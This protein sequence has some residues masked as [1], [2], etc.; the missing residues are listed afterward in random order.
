MGG[1]SLSV[2]RAKSSQGY[3]AT[4]EALP[5]LLPLGVR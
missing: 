5:E 3:V 2:P 1:G 4:A